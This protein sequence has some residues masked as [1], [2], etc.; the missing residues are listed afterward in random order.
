M[1]WVAWFLLMLTRPIG[2]QV[3]IR[4]QN[5]TCTVVPDLLLLWSTSVMSYQVAEQV[6]GVSHWNKQSKSALTNGQIEIFNFI[7][8]VAYSGGYDIWFL[9]TSFQKSNIGWPQQPPTERM[10]DIS[11]KLDF[12]WSIPQKGSGIDHLGAKDDQNIRISN[13]CDEMRLLKS[14]RPLRLLRPLRTLRLQRFWG[15]ENHYWGF[16]SHPGVWIHLYFYVLIK[17]FLGRIMKNHIEF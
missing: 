12:L 17:S 13:F 14:L 11:E 2:S 6:Q 8:K 4:T 15:L 5:I 10:S 3:K 1:E 9:S 7:S 16:Q